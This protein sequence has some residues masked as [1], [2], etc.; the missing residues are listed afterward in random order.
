MTTIETLVGQPA[1]QRLGWGLVHSLWQSTAVAMILAVTLRWLH[2]SPAGSRYLAA[3]AA[4]FMMV[5]LPA[6]TAIMV[7]PSS[8]P[9]D[10]PTRVASARPPGEEHAVA[11]DLTMTDPGSWVHASWRPVS[12]RTRRLVSGLAC[13]W[14]VGV[15]SL[16]LRLVGG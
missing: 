13:L 11:R 15:V 12:D 9:A 3:C 4:L 7:S 16:T 10:A 5:A 14:A 2:R 1:V 8:G 6:A